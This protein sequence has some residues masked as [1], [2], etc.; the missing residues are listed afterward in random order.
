MKALRHIV[1]LLTVAMVFSCGRQGRVIPARK[2]AK[3]YAQMLVA[4]Q[5]AGND[6]RLS[7]IA[8][9]SL[10][11]EPLLE[12]YGYTSRDY[13]RSVGHYMEDPEAFGKIFKNVK[14]ILDRHIDELTADERKAHRADSIR[15]AI[16]MMDFLR[17][18]VYM[19]M[20]ME[21]DSVRHDTVAVSIDSSGIFAWMR[22]LPDTLYSG[23]A[24]ALKRDLDSLAAVADSVV[25]VKETPEPVRIG[26]VP[27][28]KG[29]L[30]FPEKKKA[31]FDF[32]VKK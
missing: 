13:V 20:G 29:R 10:F 6:S 3:I 21:R 9:T 1:L 14:E 32:K 27:L 12:E 24:F 23:P 15:R 28:K 18:P 5:W 19:Y 22:I 2:F 16:E 17:P 7:R 11:Y 8:D 30:V 26:E 4:D 25:A 31:P